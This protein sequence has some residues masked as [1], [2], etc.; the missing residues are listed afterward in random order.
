MGE[1]IVVAS[2]APE[3]LARAEDMLEVAKS[4][5]IDCAEMREAAAYDLKRVKALA[6]DLD[7]QRREITRPLDLAKT[8]IMELFRKP[9]EYLELAERTIKRACLAFDG[10]QDRK[11]R[12]AEAEAARRADE[13][14]KRLEAQAAEQRKAGNVETAH[15][16]AQAATFV[17]PAPVA[18]EKPKIAGEATREIWRAEVEDLVA[19]A[20]A[21]ADGRA[22]SENILPNMPALNQQAR[23][24]KGSLAI[25][26][27][28]AVC[29]RVLATRAA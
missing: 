3:L 4:Y 24:L 29:E 27:V 17:A 19:L 20:K 6:E 23:A 1:T 7:T 14:R 28:K 21:I 8:R 9:T 5:R 22:S 26:G 12:E 18:I 11:R 13:E 2:P 10:E 16:I 25:P 15:A